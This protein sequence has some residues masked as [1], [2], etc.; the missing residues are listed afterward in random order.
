MAKL[1]PILTVALAAGLL[2]GAPQS[3]MAQSKCQR[4]LPAAPAAARK[5]HRLILQVNTNDPAAM[6]LALNNATNV[7]QHY[8]SIGET[9]SD[10]D[11]YLWAR[12]EH[13]A[14]R[15]LAGEGADQGAF[16]DLAV[17]LLLLPATIRG[18]T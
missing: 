17:D 15:H 3:G 4:H 14:G 2:V 8:K 7:E 18:R 5:A 9:D 1:R 16:G 6:N 11:R 10:R 13:A 12:P